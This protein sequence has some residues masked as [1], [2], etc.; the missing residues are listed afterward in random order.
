MTAG[1]GKA[2]KEGTAAMRT[3]DRYGLGVLAAWTAGLLLLLGMF[4]YFH[5]RETVQE[6]LAAARNASRMVLTFR[7]WDAW[8]GGVYADAAR[9]VPNPYLTNSDGDLTTTTGRRLSL[10]NPTCM[11]RMVFD[12]L[13]QEAVPPLVGKLTSLKP[14]NP[15]NAPD[16]WE[17]QALEAFERGESERFRVVYRGDGASL[18]LLSRLLVAP[19]CLACHARQGYKAGD[20]CGGIRVTVPLTSYLASEARTRNHLFGGFAL[21][22]LAGTA[23]IVTV[24]R[25]RS[26][27]EAALAA[28][29]EGLKLLSFALNHSS[30]AVFLIDEGGRFQYVNDEACRSLGWGRAELLGLTVSDI[31][32]DFP[33]ERWAE[34]WREAGAQTT[35]TFE[36]RHLHRDGRVFPVEVNANSFVYGEHTYSLTL[37]RNISERRLLEDQL[38]QAQKMEAV[39]HL[40]SGLTHEFN[41]IL[42]VIVG[43]AS[44]LELKIPAADPLQSNVQQILAATGRAGHLTRSLL[45]F[46]RRQAIHCESFDLNA[47]VGRLEKVLRRVIRED[48]SLQLNLTGETLP[49][50]VDGGLIEQVLLNLATNARDAMPDGGVMSIATDSVQLDDGFR[51]IH[52]FGEAGCYAQLVF[53]DSGTG[54]SD[55]VRQRVFEPFFTTKE[56]GRGTGLGLAVCYGIVKQHN[57]FINCY[58]EP[59]R[60]TSFR[61]YLPLLPGGAA[62]PAAP[63][64]A[65]PLP[66]GGETILLAEDDPAVR[67]LTAEVLS[68]FGYRVIE[69]ADGAAAVALFRDRQQEVQLCL[70]DAIMP[71]KSGRDAYAEIA[72]ARPGVPVIFMSGY[73]E[74]VTRREGLVGADVDFLSKPMVPGDLLR[75][76]REVL[77][78]SR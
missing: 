12:A 42:T 22:W 55:E 27:Q 31:D 18:S 54:M 68:E 19:D 10:V 62:V 15:D 58:S 48:I 25:R 70:L 72:A 45:A 16:A 30:E 1:S 51:R 46:S 21:L 77:D 78:R 67:R 8:L 23:G 74:D 50:F 26:E 71:Q 38:R 24:S 9:V 57:G 52:G 56:V 41:N 6:A 13:G 43:F 39:G 53:S 20:V 4:L 59:G 73:R 29:E 64:T 36:S 49:V 65:V 37:V 32:P 47:I 44:L 28:H 5:H 34:H 35:R 69:A 66:H 33:R 60:G 63:A 76:V 7:T 14:L 61:I 2:T 17:R 40:A 75:K 3:G 11:S